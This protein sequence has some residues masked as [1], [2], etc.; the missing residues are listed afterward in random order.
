ME[1]GVNLLTIQQILGHSN[2]ATTAIYTHVRRDHL[3]ATAGTVTLLP[4]EEL[5]REAQAADLRTRSRSAKCCGD[6][7]MRSSPEPG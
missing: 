5:R 7:A 1:A 3:Q 2:L 4:L 6:S